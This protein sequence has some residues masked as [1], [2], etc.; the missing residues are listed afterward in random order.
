MKILRWSLYLFFLSVIAEFSLRGFSH[1][2]YNTPIWDIRHL[3]YDPYVLWKYNPGSSIRICSFNQEGFWGRELED[4]KEQDL[5]RVVALGGSVSFGFG[6]SK[7]EN[8][9]CSVLEKLL[10]EK[11]AG[12]RFEVVNAGVT[13][14]SSYNGRQFVE[15]YLEAI[16]PDI[17]L[18][19]FGWN[20]SIKESRPDA[21]PVSRDNR[22]SLRIPNSLDENSYLYR[23]A[24]DHAEKILRLFGRG[25]RFA[26]ENPQTPTQRVPLKDFRENLKA[27]HTWCEN[28]HVRMLL[29]TES[30][31]YNSQS[32]ADWVKEALTY[33]QAMREVAAQVNIPLAD[34]AAAFKSPDAN[35]YFNDRERDYIHTNDAG[36]AFMASLVSQALD[37]AGYFDSAVPRVAGEFNRSFQQHHFPHR[38]ELSR[39]Q[40]H[41]IQSRRQL[42]SVEPDFVSASLLPTIR[43]NFDQPARDV[44]HP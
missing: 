19:A 29:W 15:H 18:V 8:N 43:Q 2:L 41:E 38:M 4:P 10:N 13:G 25:D 31:A 6:A 21:D 32:G 44:I 7:L 3:L 30:I 17:L 27:I 20:D 33:Q 9:F 23:V 24:S 14:Y 40:A 26:H 28:H 16:Q 35:R 37:S 11:S 22:T 5:I 12:R 34:V 39:L 36:Q 1:Y 42:R